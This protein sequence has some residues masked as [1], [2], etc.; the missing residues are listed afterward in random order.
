MHTTGP[1]HVNIF[2]KTGHNRI[3]KLCMKYYFQVNNNKHG[4]GAKLWDYVR[5]VLRR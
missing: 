4:D 3:Y 1:K 2:I 5:Q